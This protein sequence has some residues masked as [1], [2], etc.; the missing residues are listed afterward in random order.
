MGISRSPGSN[1]VTVL[2]GMPPVIHTLTHSEPGTENDLRPA[3]YHLGRGAAA[4]FGVGGIRQ[5]FPYPGCKLIRPFRDDRDRIG[6][7]H[8]ARISRTHRNYQSVGSRSVHGGEDRG[9]RRS[10][11]RVV[12][13]ET[14]EI[15]LRGPSVAKGYWNLPESTAAV[16][17]D[18]GWF[19]TGESGT[20]TRTAFSTSP[21]EK[22]H[23]HHVG[24]EDLPDRGRERDRPAPG[25]LQT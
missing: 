2:A 23:D 7:D 16:F 6:H 25:S 8:P 17:R 19:L 12:P 4:A 20:L 15:A 21:T 3:R 10:G 14:G 9:R 13:G 1:K 24:L 22:R 11:K 18:D 5:A